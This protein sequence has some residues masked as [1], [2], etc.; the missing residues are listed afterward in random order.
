MRSLKVNTGSVQGSI[1][2]DIDIMQ[3]SIMVLSMKK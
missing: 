2:G 1:N 3:D